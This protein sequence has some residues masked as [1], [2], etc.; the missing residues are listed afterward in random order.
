[1]SSQNYNYYENIKLPQQIG[2]SDKGDIKTLSKDVSGLISYVQLLVEGSGNAS[3]TKKPLGNKYFYNTGASCMDS[4]G[5]DQT[6]YIF[7][8]NI[9][10][11]TIPF[12][13]SSMGTTFKDFK[14]LIPGTIEKIG[15]LDPIK[16]MSA[17]ANNGAYP[18][19]TSIT[20]DTVDASN[21]KGKETHFIANGDIKQMNP[22]LFSN[23]IN[24]LTRKKCN[25]GFQNNDSN[26][27]DDNFNYFYILYLT[28]VILIFILCF[29]I[30]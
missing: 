26:D 25:E 30:K 23:G 17:F 18:A 22:C 5:N 27:S 15:E 21:K 10:T 29:M 8:N 7:I 4:N 28:F 2:M 19:C 16:L 24:P 11:G 13:S 12:I 1:M 9:P 20:L 6:R 3:T 14:G